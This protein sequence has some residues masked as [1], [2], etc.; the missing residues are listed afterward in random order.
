MRG[1]Y[2]VQ[3]RGPRKPRT[4]LPPTPDRRILGHFPLLLAK[5]SER[6]GGGADQVVCGQ[7]HKLPTD[8]GQ[9]HHVL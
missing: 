7:F 5:F 9:L 4:R 3:E 1:H 6:A 2:K 8:E